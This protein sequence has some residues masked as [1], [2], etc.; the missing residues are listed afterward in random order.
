MRLHVATT[1]FFS[2]LALVLSCTGLHPVSAAQPTQ[3]VC[4][5][6]GKVSTTIAKTPRGN[7][8]VINWK[9]DIFKGSGWTAERRCEEVSSRFQRFSEAGQLNFLTSGTMNGQPVICVATEEKG[10]CVDLLFTLR[11]DSK[12]TPNETLNDLLDVRARQSSAL[13]ESEGRLYINMNDFLQTAL[14]E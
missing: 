4:Q 12:K 9:S 10:G 2:T 5:K 6:R 14:V 8:P 3:F 13:T 11:P 1:T 7:V